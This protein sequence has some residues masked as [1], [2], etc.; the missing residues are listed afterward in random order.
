MKEGN[1]LSKGEELME[2]AV[3]QLLQDG[4]NIG[5]AILMALIIFVVGRWITGAIKTSVGAQWRNR[6]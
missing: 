6:S 5:K 3:Q 1:A 4:I 2:T